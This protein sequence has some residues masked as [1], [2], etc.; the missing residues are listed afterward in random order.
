MIPTHFSL[1]RILNTPFI[2]NPKRI[3]LFLVALVFVTTLTPANS[4]A[5]EVIGLSGWSL[6]LDPG[7]SRTENQGLYNYSEAEKVLRI[8]LAL[9][10]MLLTT[11]D[12]DTVYLS[13]DNDQVSVSLSQRTK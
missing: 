9:R 5:Q 8:G 6:F 4:S 3:L 13:R 1:L 7:H 2:H 10:D 11:T 12:I